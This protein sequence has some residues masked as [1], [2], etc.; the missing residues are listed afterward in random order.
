MA[1]V[2]AALPV[3]MM[4]HKAPPLP[5]LFA[6]VFVLQEEGLHSSTTHGK[7]VRKMAGDA[8]AAA[9]GAIRDVML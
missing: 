3:Y 8:P 1:I 4:L 7:S 2:R 9:P 5:L 6:T